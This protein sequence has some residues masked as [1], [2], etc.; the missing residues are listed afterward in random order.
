MPLLRGTALPDNEYEYSNV[1]IIF[2]TYMY[3]RTINYRIF[4]IFNS[5]FLPVDEFLFQQ[6]YHDVAIIGKCINSKMTFSNDKNVNFGQF[7]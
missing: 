5:T 3:K 4:A 2:A 6:I 1:Q 7:S